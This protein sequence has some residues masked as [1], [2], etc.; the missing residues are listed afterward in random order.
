MCLTDD[1]QVN[2]EFPWLGALIPLLNAQQ[3]CDPRTFI[4]AIRDDRESNSVSFIPLSREISQKLGNNAF[5]LHMQDDSMMPEMNVGDVLIVDPDQAIR[6]GK[7]VVVHLQDSNEATVR[8]YKQLSTDSV[9]GGYEL[10]PTNE[11]WANTRV[12][13]SCGHKTVGIVVA[14]FRVL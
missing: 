10:L 12:T 9:I 5:A 2:Q 11:N 13:Q 4:Q 7:L 8:R 1:K 3:A 14:F 6:P